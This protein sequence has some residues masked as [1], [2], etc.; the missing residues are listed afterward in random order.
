VRYLVKNV[1]A[2]WYDDTQDHYAT[3]TQ[4]DIEAL[5]SRASA[6]TRALFEVRNALSI[7]LIY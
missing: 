2:K 7:S 5:L 4:A 3:P 1:W 6:D